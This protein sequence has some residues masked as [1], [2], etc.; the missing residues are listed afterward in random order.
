[1]KTKEDEELREKIFGR[2]RVGKEDECWQWDGAFV[3][4]CATIY[5]DGK[6]HY[7]SRYIYMFTN[8]DF[9]IEQRQVR[10]SCRNKGCC[11]PNHI[12]LRTQRA[13]APFDYEKLKRMYLKNITM[14]A[15][16]ECWPSKNASHLSGYGQLMCNGQ[17]YMMHRLAYL[18]SHSGFDIEGSEL[19]F[20]FCD[21]SSCC[22]PK[23]LYLK[24]DIRGE[25][26][27]NVKLTEKQVIEI[28]SLYAH[29]KLKKVKIAKMYGVSVVE[30]IYILRGRAWG[31]LK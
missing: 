19:V 22:N 4:G 2:I 18:F 29:G 31:W 12:V 26:N 11:N 7:V 6:S 25:N 14:G 8:N 17:Y 28:R 27:M 21:D 16:N 15:E 1:M 10:N 9:S 23:H 13:P 30:I 20:H 5:H 24:S 3:Q